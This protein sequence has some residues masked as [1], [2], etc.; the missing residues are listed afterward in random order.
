MIQF[1]RAFFCMYLTLI[2]FSVNAADSTA[3]KL[4]YSQQRINDK[5]VLLTIKVSAEKDIKLYAL[6]KIELDALY[7]SVSFDSTY[8][9]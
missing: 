9:K 6:K 5:E 4:S 3:I 8:K 7:S 2:A 1:I